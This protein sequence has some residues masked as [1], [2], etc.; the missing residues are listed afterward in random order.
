MTPMQCEVIKGAKQSTKGR[1]PPLATS[2]I[3]GESRQPTVVR[4]REKGQYFPMKGSLS[5]GWHDDILAMRYDFDGF[6]AMVSMQTVEQAKNMDVGASLQLG[7]G[8][9]TCAASIAGV[10][11][12]GAF[13]PDDRLDPLKLKPEQG[14]AKYLGTVRVVLD[15]DDPAT[16]GTV[17]I[18]DHYME[19]AFHF[20]VDADPKS[21]SFGL[22]LRLYGMTGVRFVYDSWKIGDP[23]KDRP[24]IWSMP[25][26]CNVTVPECS[27]FKNASSVSQSI[28]V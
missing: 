10:M 17:A 19:W 8:Q 7:H 6:G 1:F 22:P 11:H 21:K 25:K 14:G 23:S 4:I 18:A 15:G 26:G 12:I 24:D 5:L 28:V 27:L 9:C 13:D 2:R 20:L 16:N 3:S